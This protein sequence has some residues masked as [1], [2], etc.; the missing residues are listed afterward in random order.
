MYIY[1]DEYIKVIKAIKYY[2]SKFINKELV[3]KIN[4]S[5]FDIKKIKDNFYNFT[6]DIY[7]DD[8]SLTNIRFISGTIS[9]N[10]VK[11]LAKETISQIKDSQS[12]S[13]TKVKL[14]EF[15]SYSENVNYSDLYATIE[16][17]NNDEKIESISHRQSYKF[18]HG[19]IDL[20]DNYSN[21]IAIKWPIINHN[22]YSK[23][24]QKCWL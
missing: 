13:F 12:I 16:K 2:V 4:T 7:F 22:N 10:Y 24:L 3:E 11:L 23:I 6:Y 21:L 9:E 1:S 15:V 8:E 14:G 5:D 19:K 20:L 18:K 17:Y